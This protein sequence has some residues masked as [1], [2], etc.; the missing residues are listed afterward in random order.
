MHNENTNCDVVNPVFFFSSTYYKERHANN[1]VTADEEGCDR[2]RMLVTQA[3]PL[4][5]G[6]RHV[7]TVQPCTVVSFECL[8][9]KYHCALF[10]RPD[11]IK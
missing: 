8:R 10:D 11:M 1:H 3:Y 6:W 4:T 7:Y 5:S 9:G 2:A